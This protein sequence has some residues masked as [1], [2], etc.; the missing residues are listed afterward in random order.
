VETA[1]EKQF[2]GA[3]V[4]NQKLSLM[5]D[6][7][8]YKK[9]IEAEV[10]ADINFNFEYEIVNSLESKR[11]GKYDNVIILVDKIRD[12]GK[13]DPG[14]LTNT[15]G[16]HVALVEANAINPNKMNE[17]YDR[18]ISITLHEF[19]HMVGLDEEY[20][21]DQVKGVTTKNYIG[22]IMGAGQTGNI[23]L[24]DKQRGEIAHYLLQQEGSIC[25]WG[26]DEALGAMDA[27]EDAR[28]FL[29]AQGQTYIG[30]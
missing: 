27:R 13:M 3:S 8:V 18:M 15:I 12:Q 2:G 28:K 16:G 5:Y 17:S 24:D 23:T 14:G 30:N 25:K 4:S 7:G 21:F 11:I 10:H 1:S 19:G 9:P 20:V 22:N 6:G 29:K 26:K